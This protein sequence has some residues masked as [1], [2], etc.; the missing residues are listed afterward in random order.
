LWNIQ[1]SRELYNIQGWSQGYFDVGE[2]GEIRVYA[3]STD[4]DRWVSLPGI[5][6]RLTGEGLAKAPCVLRFPQVMA[7]RIH[8]LRRSFSAASKEFDFHGGH[9]VFY[10]L[11]VNQHRHIVEHIT[12]LNDGCRGDILPVGFEVGSKPELLAAIAAAA[13]KDPGTSIICNGYKDSTYL[14]AALGGAALGLDVVIVVDALREIHAI[15]EKSEEFGILPAIGLRVKLAS[16]G[17]GIW[18]K[19]GGQSA[20]FGLGPAELLHCLDLLEEKGLKDSLVML[21][22]HIGSQITRARNIQQAVHEAARVYTRVTDRGFPVRYFNVGGGL[23]VDY[24]GTLSTS[25]SSANYTMQEY[26][27][28]VVYTLAGVCG[29]EGAP[30]PTILTESGRA[31]AAFHA[32]VVVELTGKTPCLP[33]PEKFDAAPGD[34]RII[35][36]MFV[37]WRDVNPGNHLEYLHDII[38]FKQRLDMHFAEGIAAIATR[39]DDLG[40]H[41]QTLDEATSGKYF[42]NFSAFQSVPDAWAINQLFPVMPLDGLDEEPG[43]RATI[44]DITCDSDGMIKEYISTGEDEKKTLEIHD[45][46]AGRAGSG[47][48]ASERMPTGDKNTKSHTLCTMEKPYY[49]GIFLTGAY[50]EVMGDYHNLFGRPYSVSVRI[51]GPGQW[52]IENIERGETCREILRYWKYGEREL[53]GA[54]ERLLTGGG[55]IPPDRVEALRIREMFESALDDYSYLTDP[56]S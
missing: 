25:N 4:R 8:E 45:V 43:I 47:G 35:E 17:S 10:P 15:M 37:T 55:G 6:D 14:R 11:K 27:N 7:A 29:E 24:E 13:G 23:G 44:A 52:E 28:H 22:F 19:S 56:H 31:L 21:H 18:E 1:D 12:D 51:T 26:A 2:E 36:E 38:F 40:E 49:M 41:M 46:L 50:Q 32:L 54:I 33:L 48:G 9:R 42:A 34:P 20:K 39:E 3:S 53:E 5:M 16:R 30:H